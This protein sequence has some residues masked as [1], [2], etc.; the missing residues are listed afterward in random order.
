[1]AQP[2]LF[3]ED[4]ALLC[5]K[6]GD[7]YTHLDEVFIAGRAR[8]DGN[9]APVHVDAAGNVTAN[10]SRVAL[11]IPEIGRRHAFSIKGWCEG[12]AGHFTIEFVQHKGQTMVTVR[13]PRWTELVSSTPEG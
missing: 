7:S 5:P 13:E 10:D 12:C 2:F 6:C 4:G 8:E 11:P 1:M 9:I 3:T